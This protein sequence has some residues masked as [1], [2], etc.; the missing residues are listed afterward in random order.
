MAQ[1]SNE[2]HRAV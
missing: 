2:Y 1:Y